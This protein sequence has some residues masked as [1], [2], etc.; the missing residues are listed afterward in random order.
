MDGTEA[1]KPEPK[2]S[3][4]LS[5][6]APLQLTITKISLQLIKNLVEVYCFEFLK[7]KILQIVVFELLLE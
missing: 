1:E 4:V 6:T 5:A 7:V 2:F 3:V